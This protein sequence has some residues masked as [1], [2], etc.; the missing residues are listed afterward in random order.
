[1][2]A[3]NPLQTR[4]RPETDSP[5]AAGARLQLPAP[6]AVALVVACIGLL[7]VIYGGWE[8]VERRFLLDRVDQGTLH[9]LHMLRGIL[10]SLV[11]AGFVGAYLLR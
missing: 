6:R 9:R 10:A 5:D 7:A 2:S 4:S 3:V 11:L 8:L 1:M